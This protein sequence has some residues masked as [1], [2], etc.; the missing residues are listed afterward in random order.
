MPPTE[1][2]VLALLGGETMSLGSIAAAT[3]LGASELAMAV[4]TLELQGWIAR[5]P[6][7]LIHRVR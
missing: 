7:A 3:N 6:G 4:T 1:A 5:G 2:S